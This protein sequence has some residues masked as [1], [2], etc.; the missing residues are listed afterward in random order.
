MG[1]NLNGGGFSKIG[2][3]FDILADVCILRKSDMKLIA[4]DNRYNEMEY[5][6]WCHGVMK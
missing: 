5:R 3:I 2:P 4:N 1:R 6:I